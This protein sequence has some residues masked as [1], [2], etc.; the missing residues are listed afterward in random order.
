V[1]RVHHRLSGSL[2]GSIPC[3]FGRATVNRRNRH[4]W[5]TWCRPGEARRNADDDT[6]R[7]LSSETTGES[8]QKPQTPRPPIP[9]PRLA[10]NP[11][12]SAPAQPLRSRKRL[13]RLRHARQLER[14]GGA[15][16]RSFPEVI[17]TRMRRMARVS[18]ALSPLTATPRTPPKTEAPA[19]RHPTGMARPLRATSRRSHA[20]CCSPLDPV[21]APRREHSLRS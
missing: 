10:E 18:H 17:G 5:R 19:P 13:P 4:P 8:T 16:E 7:S 6:P 9:T 1:L 20:R 21:G 2:A 14:A 12:W 15:F 11:Q 3:V